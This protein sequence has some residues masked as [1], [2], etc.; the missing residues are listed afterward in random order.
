MSKAAWIFPGQGDP[1]LDKAE[2]ISQALSMMIEICV[3]ADPMLAPDFTRLISERDETL[4]SRTLYS[5][6]SL[7]ALSV[8]LLRILKERGH[9][10][11][12]VMGHSMG[13]VTALFAAG[14]I[15]LDVAF[16]FLRRRAE[17]MEEIES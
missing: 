10:P 1:R 2:A 7:F 3:E 17:L 6:L 5:Q 16:R 15:S 11:Y 4:L 14:A 9:T 13:E 12:L 8:A